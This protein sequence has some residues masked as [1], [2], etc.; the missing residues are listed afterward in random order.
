MYKTITPLIARMECRIQ[1]HLGDL[2]CMM[3]Y[4]KRTVP[5]NAAI[6]NMKNGA[7]EEGMLVE[8]DK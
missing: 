2:L 6:S 3:S 4:T 1:S 5:K 7:I 8:R